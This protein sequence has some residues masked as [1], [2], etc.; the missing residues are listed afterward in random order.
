V[1]S[2][3]S[4]YVRF[5]LNDYSIPPEAVGQ[6][7]TLAASDVSVRILDNSTEIAR[8]IRSYDR[9]QL[10]LDPAH[11]EAVLK[12]KRKAFHSTPGGRLEQAV[13]ESKT[14]LDLAFTHGESAGIQTSQLMKL[15]E[16]YGAAALRRAIVE[17][18][19]RNTPRASSVA[20]LL[21]RQP[22]SAP[23]ALDLS[24][25]PEAQAIDV[26]PHNLATYDELGKSNGS[27]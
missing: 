7:L 8:H 25:H 16:E 15:L 18:L 21:R 10:V 2:R 23:L 22:R 5:D 19:Q 24:R 6:Q 1:S 11:Q 3:K 17:A 14:L 27:K 26:R 9:H 20:F 13:P 4:I 12:S